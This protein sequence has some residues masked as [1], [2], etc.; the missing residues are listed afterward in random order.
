VEEMVNTD[1]NPMVWSLFQSGVDILRLNAL[2]AGSISCCGS[3]PARWTPCILWSK[4][5][6]LKVV[7]S[8]SY[9]IIWSDYP[10]NLMGE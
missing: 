10:A 1:A 7:H 6:L 9:I 8:T 4:R 3:Q 2:K 5:I